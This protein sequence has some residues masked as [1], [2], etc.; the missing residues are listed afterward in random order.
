MFAAEPTRKKKRRFTPFLL[1]KAAKH[2][3]G[4]DYKRYGEIFQKKTKIKRIS[5]QSD[6]QHRANQYPPI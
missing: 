3:K 6:K 4:K 5:N 2:R 1:F